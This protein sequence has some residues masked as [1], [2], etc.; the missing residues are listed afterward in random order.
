MK[1]A[2]I[3][4]GAMLV[5]CLCV[6]MLVGCD[7]YTK[8]EKYDNA[9]AYSTGT[10]VYEGELTELNV[11]WILGQINL[12]EDE[13][14]TNITVVE[15]NELPSKQKVHSLFSDGVLNVKFWESGYRAKIE[16]KYK[17]VTITYPSV[18]RIRINT[19]SADVTGNAL[20]AESLDVE[21]ISGDVTLSSAR[22]GSIRVKSVSGDVKTGAIVGQTFKRETVSGESEI[23]T[24]NTRTATFESVSG[25]VKIPACTVETFSHET[26][27][28]DCTLGLVAAS[29]VAFKSV[30]G[31]L[32]ATLPLVGATVT[33]RTTSGDLNTTNSYARSGNTYTFGVAPV[34]SIRADTTS[35]DVTIR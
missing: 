22:I 3:V 34:C 31:D 5:V 8:Q 26:T 9:E 20:Q 1:K 6:L 7:S 12:V 28:G 2:W 25:D 33:F 14:A 16:G 10:Q 4:V 24:L 23:A 13:N 29:T 21:T 18:T 30:S 32:D 11:D 19:V 17:K 15:E 27:S 35:G